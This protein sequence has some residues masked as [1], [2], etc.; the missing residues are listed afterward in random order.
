MPIKWSDAVKIATDFRHELH[1]EPELTWQEVETSK[2]IRAM[3]DHYNI[4]WKSFAKTGTVGYL[5]KNIKGKHIA[6]RAD[7][8]A[9]DVQETTGL[10]Y[11]SVKKNHMHACG[12]D[13]H[14]ATL[15]AVAI[16]L[17][18]N[19]T[20]LSNQVSLVFQPAEEGGH[21][22]KKMIEEGCL[23]GVDFI[24]GWHNW[25]AIKFGQALCPD[26]AVMAGNGTF[27]ISLEGE[28][29]HSSQPEMC[30]DPV[31]A[32]SAIV[33]AL[34][35]IV[36]RQIGPQDAAVVSVTSFEAPSGLTA[37]PSFAKLAGSIRVTSSEMKEVIAD[38]IKNIAKNTAAAYGVNAIVEFKNRYNATINHKEEAENY[39][40][41]LKNNLGENWQSQ[42]KT[43]IMASEDFSYYL[44][45]IPGAFALIGS[46]D[47]EE[48]HCKPCHNA[49]Y[50]FNDKL[51]DVAGKILME[52]AGYRF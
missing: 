24:Y 16:F 9:L 4:K 31:L 20:K 2:K 34:Q 48:K 36:S 3:L 14:T 43:P 35:Q 45:K 7:I 37:I 5:G 32:G 39:R 25:P 22:A 10:K 38:S 41:I 42:V 33:V 13:G 6:L 27:T 40:E 18:E 23:D 11:A 19:E 50:D 21:G 52:C 44:E 46:D 51:I 17:S 1:A 8:D 15:M 26:G 29:G 12:H 30:K 49:S 47:G 28:G